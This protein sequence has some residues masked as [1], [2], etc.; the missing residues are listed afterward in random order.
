MRKP[1]TLFWQSVGMIILGAVF[2][3]FDCVLAHRWHPQAPWLQSGLYSGPSVLI[4]IGCLVASVCG[5]LSVILR[6]F[7]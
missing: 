6:K 4:T 7:W 2:Y 1:P 5:L 3:I